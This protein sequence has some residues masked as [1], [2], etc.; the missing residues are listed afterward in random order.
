MLIDGVQPVVTPAPAWAGNRPIRIARI[1]ARLNVGGPAQ[2]VILL[3]AGMDRMRFHT[4]LI[5]GMVGRGEG[6]LLPVARARGVEPVV[7]PQ[8]GPAIRPMHDLI[9]LGKLVRIFRQLRPD[10]VHTHT[11][12]AGTLGRLAARLAR[13]P[14]TI[15]TFH[16]H[17][18]EGYFSPMAT[19]L[20]LRIE[21]ALARI[22]DRIITVSPR[23]RQALLA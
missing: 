6:D 15:H 5:T 19:Q 20:F 23:L 22:T 8:L 3:T 4:T 2:H 18:L 12:K 13:V 16:G 11:A 14:R 10:I 17:V 7:I 1:I 21:R 9:A